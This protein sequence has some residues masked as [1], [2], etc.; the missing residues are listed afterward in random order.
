MRHAI[1]SLGAIGVSP[2]GADSVVDESEARLLRDAYDLLRAIAAALAERP[3]A[4][5]SGVALTVE[6]PRATVALGGV[7]LTITPTSD[8]FDSAS[9]SIPGYAALVEEGE[10]RILIASRGC[11]VT[12]ETFDAHPAG[13][14]S[15]T[16]LRYREGRWKPVRRLNGDETASGTAIRFPALDARPASGPIPVWNESTGLVRAEYYR[17]FRSPGPGCCDAPDHSG[18][19]VRWLVPGADPGRRGAHDDWAVVD[20]KDADSGAGFTGPARQQGDVTSGC[21]E[22]EL[23]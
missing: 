1:G 18:N 15:A 9:A 12:A 23:R 2:F 16:E 19:G 20:G 11:V 17:R 7:S 14:L 8:L 21:D 4:A 3:R 5:T 22:R 6:C 13:I 10:G